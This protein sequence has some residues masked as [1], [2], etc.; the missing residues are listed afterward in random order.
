MRI[1][2]ADIL[3]KKNAEENTKLWLEETVKLLYENNLEEAWKT[4]RIGSAREWR[5]R[6]GGETKG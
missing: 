3:K 1:D 6:G 5:S 2:V 4:Q